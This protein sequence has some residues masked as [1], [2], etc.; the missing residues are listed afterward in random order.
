MVKVT[1]L[2][3]SQKNFS[4]FNLKEAMKQLNITDLHPWQISAPAIAPSEFFQQRLKRLEAFDL[5]SFERSKELLID[6]FCEEAIQSYPK[7][8]IWKGASLEGKSVS[9]NVD[10][11]IAERKRY[12]EAPLL[13]IVEA[14]KDDF[15]QGLAQCLVELQA[16]QWQNSRFERAIDVM[17]IVTNASLWQFYQLLYSGEVY[18]TLPYGLNDLPAIL[19]ALHFV[20]H[21]CEQNLSK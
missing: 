9:G 16:C 6:A 7:L 20:F 11:L 19:G 21:H 2:R 1:Q 15:E 17:G 12:L 3:K 18:E 4:S 10:Y 5:Q 8:K 13:C 14:K